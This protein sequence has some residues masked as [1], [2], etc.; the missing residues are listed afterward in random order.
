MLAVPHRDTIISQQ[1]RPYNG[2]LFNVHKLAALGTVVL[3]GMATYRAV[4]GMA[5][6]TLVMVSV[7]V[8]AI[9]V[10]A[11]FA[12]GALMSAGKGEYAFV[13]F[14]HNVTPIL[15]VISMTCFVYLLSGGAV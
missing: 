7:V 11:L 15:F 5:G 8:A 1:G 10:V 14:I 4:T 3:S 9:C 13:K 12:S 2:L 6:Q